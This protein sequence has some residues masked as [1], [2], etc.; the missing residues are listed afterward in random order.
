MVAPLKFRNGLVISSHTLLGMWLRIHVGLKLNNVSKRGY[1]A[2]VNFWYVLCCNNIDL[3]VSPTIALFCFNF[4][5][6]WYTDGNIT[7][8]I[9][10]W[11]FS[12]NIGLNML[13]SDTFMSCLHSLLGYS[14]G[15]FQDLQLIVLVV[16]STVNKP[17]ASCMLVH[18]LEF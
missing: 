10:P 12:L 15:E 11:T 1:W 2:S 5:L 6:T 14:T 4:D 7:S 17:L 3:S 18:F 8:Y 9:S 16:F 13:P